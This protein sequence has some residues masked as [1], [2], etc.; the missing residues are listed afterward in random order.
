MMVGWLYARAGLRM[1]WSSYWKGTGI[2][3]SLAEG[4][5]CLS[6]KWQKGKAKGRRLE[7][8]VTLV[9]CEVL[10]ELR[11]RN[12]Y[13]RKRDSKGNIGSAFADLSCYNGSWQRRATM[14]EAKWEKARIRNNILVLFWVTLIHKFPVGME[15]GG[16]TYPVS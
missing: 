13:Y 7:A 14:R 1:D 16:S 3:I 10:R 9:H 11:G 15:W 12:E 5:Q 6:L 2:N 8:I 4:W